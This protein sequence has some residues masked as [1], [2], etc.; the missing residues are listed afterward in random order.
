MSRLSKRKLAAGILG[1][2]LSVLILGFV[3]IVVYAQTDHGRNFLLGKLNTAIAGSVTASD[4]EISFIQGQITLADVTVSEASGERLATIANATVKIDYLPL[5]KGLLLIK[6]LNLE[7][8]DFQVRHKKDG[9]IDL[10]TAFQ[11]GQPDKRPQ[12]VKKSGK[13]LY[14]VFEE[15][16]VKDGNIHL[17]LE[18]NN[19]SLNFQGIASRAKVDLKQKSGLLDIN[20]VETTLDF[21]ERQLIFRPFGISVS[22]KNENAADIQISA[23]TDWAS[24]ALQ[25]SVNGPFSDP[26]VQLQLEFDT[27]LSEADQFLN[28]PV[29]FSGKA[30][31]RLSLAGNWREPKADLQLSYEGGTLYGY[32]LDGLVA[33]LHMANR[34]VTIRQLDIKAGK[35]GVGLNGSLNLNSVLQESFVWKEINP[36]ALGYDLAI[37]LSDVDANDLPLTR[38][39]FAGIL[40]AKIHIR[41]QGIHIDQMSATTRVDGQVVGFH[42]GNL[43]QPVDLNIAATGSTQ[44]GVVEIKYMSVDAMG[45]RLTAHGSVNP[46]ARS[47]QANLV[48]QTKEVKK[49]LELIGVQT[50]SASGILRANVSGPWQQPQ[51]DLIMRADQ[52]QYQGMPIGDIKMTADLDPQGLLTVKSLELV[53]QETRANGAATIQLFSEG[54]NLDTRLPFRGHLDIT[55]AQVGH[56]L[57]DPPIIGVFHGRLNLEGSLQSL[58]ASATIGGKDVSYRNIHLDNIDADLNLQNGRLNVNALRLKKKPSEGLVT[59]TIQLFAGN[60]WRLLAEPTLDLDGRITGLRLEDYMASANGQVNV[61]ARISGPITALSGTGAI[62]GQNLEL[63]SQPIQSL[64]LP[65]RLKN[66]RVELQP[67]QVKIDAVNT[68]TGSGWIGFDRSYSI[69]LR[70]KAFQ[71]EAIEKVRSM[72]SIQGKMDLHIYGEG[73][74]ERPAVQ[75]DLELTDVVVNSQPIQGF[76]FDLKLEQDRVQIEGRQSFDLKAH[77]D[78]SQREY[79]IEMNLVETDLTPFFLVAGQQEV[80]GMVSGTLFAQ[81][82]TTM[83]TRSSA[84]LDLTTVSLV[85]RGDP[86]VR[87]EKLQ[88]R[89]TNQELFIADT[90]VRVLDSGYLNIQG[91]GKADGLFSIAVNGDIAARAAAIFVKDLTEIQGNIHLNALISGAWPNPDIQGE[92]TWENVGFQV[93]Q[94]DMAFENID[95]VFKLTSSQIQV[96]YLNGNLGTG[97]FQLSGDCQLHRWHPQQIELALFGQGIPIQIPESLDAVVNM[98]L[99]ASGQM[100]DLVVEGQLI[101]VEGLYYKNFNLLQAISGQ[102][103]KTVPPAPARRQTFLDGLHINIQVKYRDAFI[104]D[105][106]IAYLEIHPDLVVAGRW[107]DPVI[108]GAAKV[109]NGSL[110]YHN[111]TFVVEKGI[112]NFTS[113]YEIQPEIDIVGVSQIRDWRITLAL[114]GKP[115]RLLIS[116]SSIPAESDSDILSL[117][118]F[119]KT[120]REL[121]GGENGLT[122]SPEAMMAQLMAS[123]FGED[124]KQASGLDYLAVESPT[125]AQDDSSTVDVT[126]GKNLS[127]RMTVKYTVG[128]GKGGYRQRAAAE[129]K[130]IEN[131]LLSGFQDTEGNYGGEVIFRV[132]FRLVR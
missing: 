89:L 111:K 52:V 131:I 60:T 113:P 42:A 17:A 43:Q 68:L 30:R 109:H 67:W 53:N 90:R 56:F 29:G 117:L 24:A 110:T 3:G 59:G 74:F 11:T 84:Y 126:V 114:E 14:L 129:Y 112:I 132:E 44:T 95:A 80:S 120:T 51:M 47:I 49:L 101:L 124:I 115:D 4:H 16:L 97:N 61:D 23:Q 70:A 1:A 103:S 18:A 127:D 40:D 71:L 123:S 57:A 9:T 75:A 12:L 77:Y 15:I 100:N 62:T 128:S 121:S 54:F 10:L 64:I 25:G 82:N 125:D 94:I 118:V 130:L 81:G 34:Q 72:G 5:L 35:G 73:S 33:D 116:L 69:D 45:A 13:S 102:N 63:R 99:T 65:V 39:R 93:P 122:D 92:I 19:V 36:D 88:A 83:L 38:D 46:S 7:R 48:V 20:V 87:T 6:N 76:A 32:T 119:G 31:G 27:S 105:N 91:S 107:Y 79:E 50:I 37:H 58:G 78:L 106:N 21:Q 41:G 26:N 66:K 104:V 96:L 85:H 8:P 108:T 28:L 98:D 2:I 22:L 55:G 86:L